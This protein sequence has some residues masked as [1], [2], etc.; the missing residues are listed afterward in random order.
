M[1]KK[2]IS[3]L[4]AACMSVV[5]FTGCGKSS[6]S[7]S[8]NADPTKGVSKKEPH[9]NSMKGKT[10]G[11]ILAGSD[12]YYQKGYEVFDALATDA[13]AKVT[14]LSSNYDPKVETNNVQDLIAKKV[15]AIVIV[16]VSS[17]N[18][19]QMAK[20]A[21]EAKIPIFFTEALPNNNVGK[22]DGSVSGDWY[23][24]GYNEG[25]LA[26][27][28]YGKNAKIVMIEGAYGTATPELHRMGFDQGF[29]DA[30]GK[31]AAQVFDQN[32]VFNQ[33]AQWATDKA[34]TVMQD[35]LAK[36]GGDFNLIFVQNEAM[37]DGV[38]K[39]LKPT[40]KTYPIY[41]INGQE[42]TIKQVKAGTIAAT[43]SIPPTSEAEMAF[44]QMCCKFAGVDYPKYLKNVNILVVKSNA[45]SKSILPWLNVT[46]YLS[47]IKNGKTGIDISVM[48][49]VGPTDPDWTK[50][51][52][53]DG[54]K[55]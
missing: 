24:S 33:T 10:I 43:S 52:S 17:A 14:K 7:S 15:D 36:T 54:A 51:A 3:I 19:A 21:N 8:S 27:E 46:S 30:V 47:M 26:G 49:D 37:K 44:Q 34:Q 48:T 1:S 25:K 45:S 11:Y 38:I 6:S 20:L 29:G 32:V 55:S 12:I 42:T 31:T 35:A 22:P 4:L 50:I 40:G 9:S 18:G 23:K 16:T 13:G 2:V 41:T 5:L 39:A 53:Q 28:K